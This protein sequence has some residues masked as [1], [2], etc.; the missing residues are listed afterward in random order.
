M[1]G[2]TLLLKFGGEFFN[3]ALFDVKVWLLMAVL[4]FTVVVSVLASL[5]PA[6]RAAKID[7]ITALRSY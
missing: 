7:P 6:A 1:S 4:L 3:F 5:I 2:N